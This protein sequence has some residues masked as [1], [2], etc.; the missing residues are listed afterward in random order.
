MPARSRIAASAFKNS[1][2]CDCT[3]SF[4]TPKKL[5]GFVTLSSPLNSKNLMCDAH[6]ATY[7]YYTWIVIPCP[8]SASSSETVPSEK[9]ASSLGT[10]SSS[11][12]RWEQIPQRLRTDSLWQP[13]DHHQNWP[14]DNQPRT[15]VSLYWHRDTAGQEEFG[16]LRPLA[17]PG[18]D[19]FIIAFSVVEPS[20]FTNARK[21]VTLLSCSGTLK[22]KLSYPQLSKYLWA[23]KSILD[24]QLAKTPKIPSQHP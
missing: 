3:T 14:K 1:Q 13:D 9:L 23:T 15:M 17:Y 5:P 7:W 11:Q 20:S 24:N 2:G 8:S 18:T 12:F 21:K 6:I 19:V 4:F 22:Y 10:S 16:R